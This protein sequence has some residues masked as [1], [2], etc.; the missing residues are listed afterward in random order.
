MTGATTTGESRRFAVTTAEG[1]EP[2][3]QSS[4]KLYRSGGCRYERKRGGPG[5]RN[6]RKR[7]LEERARLARGRRRGDDHK[8]QRGQPGRRRRPGAREAEG[9]GSARRSGKN[10]VCLI[11]RRQQSRVQVERR[12]RDQGLL[13]SIQFL[14]LR[15][16]RV[17][18]TTKW[19]FIC[20]ILGGKGKFD[21]G[22]CPSN[23]GFIESKERRGAPGD[24]W[25]RR[26]RPHSLAYH[27]QQRHVSG[28][29]V[30]HVEKGAKSATHLC[31]DANDHDNYRWAEAKSTTGGLE[32]TRQVLL[33]PRWQIATGRATASCEFIFFFL[34]FNLEVKTLFAHMGKFCCF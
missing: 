2:Y 18:F 3:K 20:V 32:A 25:S 5:K 13:L 16:V 17:M 28:I 21:L 29:D 22:W 27:K 30:A 4:R 6:Q 26:R 24:A 31:L 8:D 9:R 19:F 23:V 12:R 34:N 1:G 7:G 15:L 10:Y 11:G 33:L 14:R